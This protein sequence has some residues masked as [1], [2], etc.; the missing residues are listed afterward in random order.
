MNLKK[1][2]YF[3]LCALFLNTLTACIPVLI[4]GTGAVAGYSLSSDSA[5]GEMKCDYRSLWDIT[6]D[7]LESMQAEISFSNESKGLIKAKISGYSV[8]VKIDELSSKI[9]KLKISAR[10]N[11]LPKP[12]FAQKIFLKIAEDLK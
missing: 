1:I 8:T 7:K 12:Q 6:V 5:I 9:Q 10:K 2:I 3:V 4:V 11:L